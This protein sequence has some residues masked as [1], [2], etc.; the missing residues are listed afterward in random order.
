MSAEEARESL[1]KND[2][3]VIFLD[4]EMPGMSGLELLGILTKKPQ[5]VLVTGKKEYAVDAFE[6][7][8]IDYLVKPF[9]YSRFLKAVERAKENHLMLLE[10]QAKEEGEHIFVKVSSTWTKIPV[11]KILYVQAMSDY[12]G[13][14]V[15]GPTENKRYVIH[16]TMKGVLNK[17]GGTNFMQIHRSYIINTNFIEGFDGEH[18]RVKAHDVPVGVTHKK[19]IARLVEKFAS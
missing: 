14:Y 15:E 8:V 17:L 2:V 11:D 18:V 9:L 1:E 10:S 4:V 6:H 19:K 13:I 5:I 16:S 12:V 7:D 3:D